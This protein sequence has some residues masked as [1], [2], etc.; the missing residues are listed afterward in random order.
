MQ[1][2]DLTAEEMAFLAQPLAA[3]VPLATGTAAA[4]EVP[5]GAGDFAARLGQGLALA[6]S[7]RLRLPLQLVPCSH[8]AP[9]PGVRPH[10]HVSPAFANLWLAR[11]QGMD[12]RGIHL[13]ASGGQGRVHVPRALLHTLDAVLA[14][15]WLDA[16]AALPGGLAWRLPASHADKVLA[17]DL[18]ASA[19][20]MQRWARETIAA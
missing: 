3:R 11:R 16:A 15:R 9:L 10:W 20:Q 8:H 19:A 13:A 12:A 7:A 1:L 4:G 17:L 2:L 14:E 6:L 5:D 18:P